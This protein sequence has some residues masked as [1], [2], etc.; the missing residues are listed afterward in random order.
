MLTT[1]HKYIGS[2]GEGGK[3]DKV[4]SEEGHDEAETGAPQ[5]PLR[6]RVNSAQEPKKGNRGCMQKEKKQKKSI[7][8]DSFVPHAIVTR[9]TGI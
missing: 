3:V 1:D 4:C 8:H 2:D 6:D 5:A 9:R 7:I